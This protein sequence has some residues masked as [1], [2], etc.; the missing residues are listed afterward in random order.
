MTVTRNLNY[1]YLWVDELCI[2]QND[3]EHRSSQIKR[4]DQ[5]YKE[6]DLTIVGACGNGK[7]YGLS[8]VSSTR[9]TKHPALKLDHGIIFSMGPD[10]LN[11]VK[12][13]TWFSRAWWVIF[14]VTFTHIEK[15]LRSINKDTTRGLP[16]Q[17]TIDLFRPPGKHL[18]E[19][20]LL[21]D[22]T[23]LIHATID[24]LHMSRKS[25]DRRTCRTT[26]FPR[27]GCQYWDMGQVMDRK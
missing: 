21:T 2:N 1:R 15:A 17:A 13:S 7:H 14:F 9:R 8:G 3:P 19:V 23:D 4:M 5:I 18:K 12:K 24:D 6:A 22:L 20:R 10:P 25:L 11:L 16:V 27:K 26:I